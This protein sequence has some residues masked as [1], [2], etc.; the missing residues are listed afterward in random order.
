M[1]VIFFTDFTNTVTV[2]KTL[3]AYKCAHELRNAGYSCLVIDHFHAFS[4][5]EMTFLEPF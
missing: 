5:K 4:I 2:Q 3:G 1:N